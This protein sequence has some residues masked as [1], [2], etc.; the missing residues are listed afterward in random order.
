MQSVTISLSFRRETVARTHRS[1]GTTRHA[2]VFAVTSPDQIRQDRRETLCGAGM[3]SDVRSFFG[4]RVVAAA[5]TLA[6][7]G[8]GMGFYGPPIYLHAVHAARGWSL[9]LVSAA[10]TMH[11][12]VGAIMVANLPAIYRRFGLAPVT[13]VGGLALAAGVLGWSVAVSPWQLFAATLVS[14]VGWATTGAAAINAIV[15]QWFVRTRPAAL[16]MAYNG[17]SIGGVVFSP[18]WVAAIAL[19]GFP[20]AAAVVGAVMVLTVWILAELLFSRVP[21]Q[22]GL[23]PDGDA[24]GTTAAPVTSP[25]ARPL[26]RAELW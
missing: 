26:P 3:P 14:G 15:S 23:A 4:W 24:L 22:M 20:A 2:S 21:Q 1:W 5:F 7:C 16:A 25:T 6:V 8:W 11:F 18:L 10:V 19:L 12:L 17:A 13:K 9:A